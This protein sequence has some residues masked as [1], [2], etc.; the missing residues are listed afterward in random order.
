MAKERNLLWLLT[1]LCFVLAL[2]CILPVLLCGKKVKLVYIP[3][4]EFMMGS[5]DGEEDRDSD[6]AYH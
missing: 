3:P 2:L 1:T 6:I 4:G 5:P